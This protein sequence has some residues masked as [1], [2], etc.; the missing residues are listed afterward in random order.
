[1]LRAAG[2]DRARPLRTYVI[3]PSGLGCAPHP[4]ERLNDYG[5]SASL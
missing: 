3:T 4:R 1:M 5:G 2:V